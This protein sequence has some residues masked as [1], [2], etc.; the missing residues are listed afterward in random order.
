MRRADDHERT[1]SWV[2][3]IHDIGSDPQ[4]GRMK[5]RYKYGTHPLSLLAWEEL[6]LGSTDTV[7]VTT[8]VEV[9]VWVTPFESVVGKT[10][11]DWVG[12]GVVE[13]VVGGV[14][15]VEVEVVVPAVVVEESVEVVVVEVEVEVVEVEVGV[16]EVEVVVVVGGVVVVEV[17]VV[18]VVGRSVVVVLVDLKG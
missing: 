10:V 16:V 2:P 7:G 12:V 17:S 14:C 11:W 3:S 18:V 13:V 1:R 4:A 6:W 15:V 8:T 5:E 9:E